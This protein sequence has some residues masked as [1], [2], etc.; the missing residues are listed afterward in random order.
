MISLGRYMEALEV[1]NEV[2]RIR[3][4]DPNP[5]PLIN[6]GVALEGLDRLEE[7]LEAYNEALRMMP[8]YPLAL[9]VSSRAKAIV[10]STRA[11]RHMR[12]PILSLGA[13][14]R[15]VCI[16]GNETMR[17]GLLL[18]RTP[19]LETVWKF[20]IGPILAPP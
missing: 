14:H 2:L 20:R 3:P 11:S 1:L 19:L 4:N 10:A 16:Q 13:P 8:N 18:P 5:L 7:A 9:L 6:K 12:S 17:L 15:S